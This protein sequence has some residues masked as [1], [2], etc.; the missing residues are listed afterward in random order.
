MKLVLFDHQIFSIQA[1]GGVSRYFVELM[2]RI[3]PE[4]WDVS[5]SIS[6]SEYLNSAGKKIRRINFFKNKSF[7]G[8]ERIIFELGKPYSLYKIAVGNYG[9]LHLTHYYSYANKATKR[10]VV[11]TYHDKVHSTYCY[12][13]RIVREQKKCFARADKIIVVSNYTKNDLISL[14]NVDEK[15]IEV[16]YHGINENKYAPEERII[17]EKYIL[18]V[19]ER[20]LYKNFLRFLEAFAQIIK[21]DMPELKLVCTGYPFRDGELRKMQELGIKEGQISQR[22]YSDEELRNL[23]QNAELFVFP[24][25][26]E[27]FGIPL[28]EAMNNNCPVICSD[29]TCFPEIAGDAAEYFNPLEIDD[30]AA[31]LRR[32]LFSDET[33]KRLIGN[34][35]KRCKEF[36]WDKSAQ[37]H[38][39]L[40]KSLV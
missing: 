38:V 27:G 31:A 33:R 39:D 40:Y 18:F 36:T 2:K 14:F 4:L 23:Y 6:N 26:H 22:F 17:K 21:K 35:Q 3:D 12:S 20:L 32:V 11:V 1:F 15:K 30:I 16:I 37:K 8:K 10:P 5:V 25:E 7:K 13:E 24:S 34:G 9:V 19:G 29:T 28:L